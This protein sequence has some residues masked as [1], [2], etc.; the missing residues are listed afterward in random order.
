MVLHEEVGEEDLTQ[1]GCS[2]YLYQRPRN[3]GE[4]N[5]GDE[6]QLNKEPVGYDRQVSPKEDTI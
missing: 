1:E 2:Y 3:H 5:S 4:I 6:V